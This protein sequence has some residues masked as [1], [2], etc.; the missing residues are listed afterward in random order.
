MANMEHVQV[1]KKGRDAVAQWR[2]EH[3]NEVLDLNAAYM[4]YARMPQVNLSGADIRNS[5]LMGAVLQRADLSGCYLNPCHMYHANLKQAN[6]T[7]AFMNGANLRGANLSG[8]DLTDVDLDRAVLSGADLTGANLSGANL[9]RANL[10]GTILTDA[11][12]TGAVLNRSTLARCVMINAN[13]EAADFYEAVFHNADVSGAKLAGSIMGYTVFQKCDLSVAEGLEK[14]RH[15]APSTVGIDT[16][17]RS[18]GNI[19]EE[20]LVDAGS[21]ASLI[22]FQ[23]SLQGTPVSKEDCFISCAA[24][25]RQ[26]AQELQS[27]LRDQ[28]IRCWLFPE[29]AR[30]H[31]LVDRKS[32][33]DQEEVERWVRDYDKLVVICSQ[34]ALDSET[35]RNDITTAKDTQFTRDQWI[36][37]LVGPDGTVVEPRG[38]GL[39]R[40]LADEH[41][42]FDLRDRSAGSYTEEINRLAEGLKGSQPASAGAPASDFSGMNPNQL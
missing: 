24:G 30:G 12:L 19:P 38:R 40:N 17:F 27:E 11:N 26:F 20:F 35:I 37:F 23:R 15:D 18:G 4:S 9:S 42:V 41:T 34:E 22:E 5:D 39:A 3:P 36:L 6:L 1:A 32:T 13:F 33:S 25:D 28:G 31:A 16:F 2:S 8:A 10:T 14:I 21:P 29:D 7:K